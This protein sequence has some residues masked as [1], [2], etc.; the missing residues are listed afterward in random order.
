M[1]ETG[2]E[3]DLELKA[4]GLVHGQHLDSVPIA[5][6]SFA[7]RRRIG[8]IGGAAQESIQ[9]P[10][11]VGEQRGR[12]VEPLVHH[13]DRLEPS[14]GRA[15]VADGFRSLVRI[16]TEVEE[17]ANGAVLDEDR[18]RQAGERQS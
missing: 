16:E 15:Q 9:R 11:D 6:R 18:V 10:N 3:H 4:L 1:R 8:V 12:A 5:T 13:L 14:D 2:T 7:L 17:A